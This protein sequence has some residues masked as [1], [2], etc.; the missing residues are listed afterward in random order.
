M[1]LHPG[2]EGGPSPGF[3][4]AHDA[5]LPAEAEAFSEALEALARIYQLQDPRQTCSY[6]ITLTE[7][8]ALEALV[9][10]GPTTVTAVAAALHLDKSTASRALAGL[11]RKKMA[12]RREN[13]QDGR[14]LELRATPSGE[15]LYERIRSGGRGMH[16]ELLAEFPSE[17]RAAAA[18]LLHRITAAERACAAA[19][20]SPP[21]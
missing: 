20:C 8:Y 6:G 10:R 18:T 9:R 21:S 15:R 19:G 2:V 5:T 17:V 14:A 1:Q 11:V 7:C 13:P 12:R 4:P 16:R 3:L